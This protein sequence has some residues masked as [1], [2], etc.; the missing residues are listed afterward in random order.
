MFDRALNWAKGFLPGGK[1]RSD[2]TPYDDKA[3]L[4]AGTNDSYSAGEVPGAASGI[5]QRLRQE[6][7]PWTGPDTADDFAAGQDLPRERFAGGPRS[8]IFPWF[9]PYVDDNSVETS[10]MRIAYRRMSADPTVSGALK[11]LIY[12]VASLDLKLIPADR[13]SKFDQKVCDFVRWNLTERLFEG[14]TG[15]VWNVLSGG[16]TDGYS[17]NYKVFGHETHGEY[18]GKWPLRILKP[19][20]TGNDA[21]LQTDAFRNVVGVL[22]LRYNGGLEFSPNEFVIYRHCPMYNNPNGTS[23]L[24]CIYQDW[25]FLK[26]VN[27]LRGKYAEFKSGPLTFGEYENVSQQKQLNGFL[28]KIRSTFYGSVPK[29]V[30]LKVLDI[31]GS[32]DAVFK[33]F[34]DDKIERIVYGIQHATLQALTGG[35]GEQRGSS[36][37]HKKQT[38]LVRIYLSKGIENCLN[39]SENGLIRDIVDLNYVVTKYPRAVLQAVDP[40]AQ[41]K[42]Q[43]LLKGLQ[44]MGLKLSESEVYDEF[45]VSPPEDEDDVLEVQQPGAGGAPGEQP[46]I[47]PGDAAHPRAPGM[48]PGQPPETPPAPG[49]EQGQEQPEQEEQPSATETLTPLA[50]GYESFYEDDWKEIEAGKR[51]GKRWQN[52][53]GRIVSSKQNPDAGKKRPAAKVKP[54]KPKKAAKPT[55]DE[56]HDRIKAHLTSSKDMSKEEVAQVATHVSTLT[57]AQVGELKKRLGLKASGNKAKMAQ[58]IAERALAKGKAFI[59]AGS[60]EPGKPAEQAKPAEQVPAPEKKPTPVPVPESAKKPAPKSKPTSTVPAPKFPPREIPEPK[61]EQHR[62]TIKEFREDI[63]KATRLS[64]EQK[65]AFGDAAERVIRCMPERAV[66]LMNAGLDGGLNW[67]PDAK[68]I[69]NEL[70]DRRKARGQAALEGVIVNGYYSNKERRCTLDG[71]TGQSSTS[72]D[73][74]RKGEKNIHGTYAHELMHAIDKGD[75][76]SGTPEWKAIWQDEIVTPDEPDGPPRLSKYATTEVYEGFAEFGRMLYGSDVPREVMKNRFPRAAAF[77]K[78]HDL[79]E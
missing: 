50:E 59:D 68:S 52:T 71:E 35:Q 76:F 4:P 39:D 64:P 79:W 24:R 72:Q 46:R 58:Q 16:L 30:E 34:C 5:L 48:P 29:G 37:V 20:D 21:V 38:D 57:T 26:V 10:E 25:W 43:K 45:S 11:G 55:V 27:I 12:S 2:S 36:D 23:A 63:D 78:E 22:G 49:E 32:A 6:E 14:F 15:L 7:M 13:K 77:M 8:V 1:S 33:S 62:V 9:P 3:K 60:P 42:R 67:H 51:G 54:E 56:V 28:A 18:A 69:T 47:P 66:K 70:N 65:K 74:E 19:V 40:E 61:T 53:K 31:A 41:D 17:L 73:L 44:E 75:R